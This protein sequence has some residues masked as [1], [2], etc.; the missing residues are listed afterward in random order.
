MRCSSKVSRKIGLFTEVR[1]SLLIHLL[2]W[3]SFTLI[4]AFF[5]WSIIGLI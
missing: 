5:P 3:L 1:W 2:S 4:G